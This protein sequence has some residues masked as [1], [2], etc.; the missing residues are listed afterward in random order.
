MHTIQKIVYSFLLISSLLSANT[1]ALYNKCSSC[2]GNYGQE[3]ALGKSQPI[4]GKS[5][6]T[7]YS[8]LKRYAK[9]KENIYGYGSL[10]KMQVV[11]L[12]DK[13]LRA[14]AKYIS[15]L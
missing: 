1:A 15:K 10:M 4:Q 2:H 6:S 5:A 7:L 8:Q 12:S 3:K 13:E 11:S 9:G 14:L